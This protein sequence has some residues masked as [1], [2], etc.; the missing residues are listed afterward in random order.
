MSVAKIFGYDISAQRARHFTA[1]S[2]DEFD[3]NLVMD[4]NNYRDVLQLATNQERRDKVSFFLAEKGE[5]SDP[6]YD[7]LLFEPV[8]KQ[9]ELRCRQLIA[10]WRQEA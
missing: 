3:Q 6:Y 8:F 2:F 1:A 4:S 5:V 7:N 10:E 9:I